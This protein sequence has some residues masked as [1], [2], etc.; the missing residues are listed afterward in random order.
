[1]SS[2]RRPSPHIRV[3]RRQQTVFIDAFPSDTFL[4]VKTKLSAI[5]DMPTTSIQL[6]ASPSSKE[7]K[8]LTDIATLADHEI[9]ND[10]IIYMCWKKESKY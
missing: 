8:E 5:F 1:M 2:D 9:P 6:W 10:G 7:A 4:S 3:K